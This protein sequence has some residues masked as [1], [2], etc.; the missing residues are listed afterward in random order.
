M[1]H[2]PGAHQACRAASQT[3]RQQTPFAASQSHIWWGVSVENRKYGLPRIEHLRSVNAKVRFLSV[4][5]LLEDLGE[6]NLRNIN[7]VIVGGE[8]GPGARPM[9]RDWVLSIRNQCRSSA[10]PFSS[11]SGAEC[12]NPSRAAS[13]TAGPTTSCRNGARSRSWRPPNPLP[14]PKE[15]KLLSELMAPGI[16]SYPPSRHSRSRNK[17][18]G[19]SRQPHS[20]VS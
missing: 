20:V 15:S 14:S 18:H 1:A 2:L 19:H 13:W 4:E 7:W 16:S 9:Q 8:S 5:P 3:P 12:A 6:F 17:S 10:F 11:N